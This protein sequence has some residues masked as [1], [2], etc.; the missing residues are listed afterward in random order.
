[1]AALATSEN[2]HFW[3]LR[4]FRNPPILTPTKEWNPQAL[5]FKPTHKHNEK[6]HLTSR[7]RNRRD[8]PSERFG[9]SSL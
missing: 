6:I 2:T 3:A 4:F 9:D 7:C 8:Q 5:P 1:V